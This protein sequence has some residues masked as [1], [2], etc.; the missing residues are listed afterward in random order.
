MGLPKW[1]GQEKGFLYKVKGFGASVL[2]LIRGAFCKGQKWSANPWVGK[3]HSAQ[4]EELKRESNQLV[5]SQSRCFPLVSAEEH[6]PTLQFPGHT[7]SG[8]IQ[9]STPIPM[10][11]SDALHELDKPKPLKGH[12]QHASML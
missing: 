8:V 6:L 2:I 7:E 12:F 3:S 5:Q 11:I 9:K 10:D 4:H 1:F